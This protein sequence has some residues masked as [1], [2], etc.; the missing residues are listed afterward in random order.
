MYD[1]SPSAL[2]VTLASASP[3]EEAALVADSAAWLATLEVVSA[4]VL[5]A[6]EAASAVDDVAWVGSAS[7][8]GDDMV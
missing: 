7:V 3:A 2:A 5:S 6:L 1:E 8:L 4:A